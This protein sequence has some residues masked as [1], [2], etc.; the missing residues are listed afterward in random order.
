MVEPHF[1]TVYF[2]R[3]LKVK[4]N[5]DYNINLVFDLDHKTR[6]SEVELDLSYGP[7]PKDKTKKVYF[8]TSLTKKISNLKNAVVNYKIKAQAPEHVSMVSRIAPGIQTINA[9]YLY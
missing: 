5:P 4:R 1:Y 7:N 8:L 9:Y 3:N 2:Y 6:H